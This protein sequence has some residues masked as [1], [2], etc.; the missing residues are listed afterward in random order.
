[1]KE[2]IKQYLLKEL[3]T[4][5]Y[6]V[7]GGAIGLIMAILFIVIGFW[8]TILLTVLVGG[9]FFLGQ[10]LDQK[11]FIDFKLFKV[12]IEKIRSFG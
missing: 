4:K 12:I 6:S 3:V 2:E 5:K 8:K 9:G 11:G 7:I 1:M 10:E